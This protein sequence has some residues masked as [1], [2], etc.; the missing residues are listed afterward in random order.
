MNLTANVHGATLV[1]TVHE[2]RIDAASAIQ[3]KD[4][5]RAL[6]GDAPGR[7][8]LD[9]GAVGFVD[10]G[11]LGAI[12]SVMKQLRNGQNLEL[13]ALTPNVDRVF[14]LT[15][16]DTVFPIHERIEDAVDDHAD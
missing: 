6:S 2:P 11:G 8:V 3:F 16:M 4:R 12:V 13:A 1:I 10:S 14:R 9:L 5:M 7:I 15:R